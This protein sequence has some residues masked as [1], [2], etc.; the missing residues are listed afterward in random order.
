MPTGRVKF[1]NSQRGFGFIA[2]E[3]G[4]EVFVHHS[5]IQ[6]SGNKT[7]TEGEE[8]EFDVVET[9]KGLQA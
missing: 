5:A 4:G 1:F 3:D 7:L 8:V 6:G 2:S 9:P